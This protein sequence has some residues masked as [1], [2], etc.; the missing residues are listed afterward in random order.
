M[1][2]AELILDDISKAQLSDPETKKNVDYVNGI[3]RRAA[4]SKP[5]KVLLRFCTSPVEIRGENGHVAAVKIEKNKLV[6]DGKGSVKAQGT[7]QFEVLP[8][9]LIFRSVGYRGIPIP[10]VSFDEK[11]GHIPNAAGRVLNPAAKTPMPGEYVVGW[12]KRGPSGLIGTNR[13]DSVATVQAMIEDAKKDSARAG[14]VRDLEAIPQRLAGG[15]IRFVTFQDWKT[16][17]R[18]EVERGSRAGKI[19]E[20]FTRVPEMLAALQTTSSR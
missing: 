18:L 19:R 13:A 8:M 10:G 6:P 12:A 5:K 4:G 7:G 11:S 16:L 1:D 20:K 17:D 2:P 15:K 3:S 9:G 14:V